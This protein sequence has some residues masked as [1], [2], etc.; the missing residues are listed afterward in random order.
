MHPSPIADT[1]R[2]FFPSLRFCIRSPRQCSVRLF[3]GSRTVLLIAD[4]FH[5]VNNLAIL[6]LLD[7]DVGHARRQ[8]CAVPMLFGWREPDDITGPDLL[9]CST[10]ALSP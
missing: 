5:P 2:P 10:F 4:M 9:D 8:R 1:S 6:L 7:G 3:S